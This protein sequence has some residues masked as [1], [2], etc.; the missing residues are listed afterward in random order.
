MGTGG[1]GPGAAAG[2]TLGELTVHRTLVDTT[3]GSINKYKRAG[4]H[5]STP[6]A[7]GSETA[8]C[9]RGWLTTLSS[10]MMADG[11]LDQSHLPETMN[12]SLSL[13]HTH[14]HTHWSVLDLI[15]CALLAD[16]L[17]DLAS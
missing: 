6:Q 12:V 17:E 8:V 16:S 4:A 9:G 10:G 2:A 13:T 14:T 5:A 1:L 15:S 11:T 3:T 7:A